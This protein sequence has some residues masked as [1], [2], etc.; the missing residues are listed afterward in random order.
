MARR[1]SLDSAELPIRRHFDPSR[2][3]LRSLAFAFEQALPLIRKPVNNPT[4]EQ[5]IESLNLHITG[6]SATSG[7]HS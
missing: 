7:A 6:R 3:Q 5:T 1:S 4:K 2:S